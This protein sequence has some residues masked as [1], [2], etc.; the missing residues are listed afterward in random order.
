M[1]S[2]KGCSVN[3]PIVNNGRHITD[4]R[5]ILR[6]NMDESEA[7]EVIDKTR[8]L[9]LQIPSF[10]LNE[11]TAQGLLLG[12]V[13]SGKTNALISAIAMAADNGYKCFVVL[14]SDNLELY[15]QT[16]GRIRANLPGLR[17]EGKSDWRLQE[18]FMSAS[19]TANNSGLVLVTT[20]NARV[21]TSLV[22][23]I[24][25]LREQGSDFLP[26][27]LIIDDEADQASLDTQ[28]R[29]RTVNPDLLLVA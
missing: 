18:R 29:Q 20:K 4:L 15:N 27:A 10:D 16:V 26:A 17:V 12:L 28:T 8:E 23:L 19:L 6:L 25:R 7:G 5:R 3:E 14:T 13:Q 2:T 24:S 9:M 22:D 1:R 11:A 21:L